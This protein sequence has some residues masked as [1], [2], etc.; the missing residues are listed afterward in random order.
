MNNGFHKWLN[1]TKFQV[2]FTGIGLI[3]MMVP[4]FELA[5]DIAASKIVEI[6]IAYCA[7]RLGEPVVESLMRKF[8][9][10]DKRYNIVKKVRPYNDEPED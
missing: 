9:T 5:P 6:V 3:F 4:L 7:A 8:E 1:S 10:K 2:S